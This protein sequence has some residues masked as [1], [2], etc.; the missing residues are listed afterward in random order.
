MKTEQFRNIVVQHFNDSAAMPG[1]E[2][3]FLE[4]LDN[5]KNA[6]IAESRIGDSDSAKKALLS[7]ME[8]RSEERYCA[9]W[10]HNL[11]IEIFERDEVA[12]WLRKKAGGYW[13][14]ND[15]WKPSDPWENRTIFIEDE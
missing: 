3:A 12:Q 2:P 11:H 14:W 7:Y 9:G 5:Y 10:L 1:N 13:K 8:W 6:L 15:E 4:A